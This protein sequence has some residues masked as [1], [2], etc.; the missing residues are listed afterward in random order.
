M[1]RAP[2]GLPDHWQPGDWWDPQGDPWQYHPRDNPHGWDPVENPCGYH[3][4]EN[5]DGDADPNG[6]YTPRTPRARSRRSRPTP[7]TAPPSRR[8]GP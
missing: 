6:R 3:P 4:Q 8:A 2:P 5:P 1:P 7:T